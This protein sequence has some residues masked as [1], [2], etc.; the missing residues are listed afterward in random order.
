MLLLL[1]LCRCGSN[2]TELI[3]YL[4][5]YR[6][7]DSTWVQRKYLSSKVE[8]KQEEGYAKKSERSKI[9]KRVKD[10]KSSGDE[11][12]SLVNPTCSNSFCAATEAPAANF[13]TD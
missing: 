9:I 11:T 3:R 10:T 8:E 2:K 1:I 13:N 12:L 7:H 4:H 6:I 5:S